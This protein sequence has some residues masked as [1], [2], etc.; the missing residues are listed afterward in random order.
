MKGGKVLLVQGVRNVY[1]V[2]EGK[3]TDEKDQEAK[4][5]LIGKGVGQEGFRESLLEVL[6]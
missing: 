3:D 1:D 2:N 4:L 5:V 6:G